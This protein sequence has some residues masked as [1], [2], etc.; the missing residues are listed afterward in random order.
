MST[1]RG[2]LLLAVVLPACHSFFVPLPSLSPP[3]PLWLRKRTGTCAASRNS[4]GSV[5]GDPRHSMV[6]KA[7]DMSVA[8]LKEELKARHGIQPETS[9][10]RADLVDKLQ[11]LR[12]PRSRQSG[13]HG[14]SGRKPRGIGGGVRGADPAAE[15]SWARF[16]CYYQKQLESLG[17]DALGEMF[18]ALLRP[19]PVTFRVS[20][21]REVGGGGKGTSLTDRRLEVRRK[22]EELLSSGQDE[23]DAPQVNRVLQQL[24]WYPNGAAWQLNLTPMAMR[25]A[26]F[27]KL[28]EWLVGESE[29]GRIWRQEAVSMVPVLLLE[30]KP[31]MTVL[32][33]C[34]APGSKTSQLLEGVTAPL[35]GE[36]VCRG[37][38]VANDADIARAQMMVHRCKALRSPN[39]VVTCYQGQSFPRLQVPTSHSHLPKVTPSARETSP[40]GATR[41]LAPTLLGGG[42]AMEGSDANSEDQQ[43]RCG[44]EWRNVS[45]DAVLCDV[46]CSGDGTLRKYVVH[47][48]LVAPKMRWHPDR[49]NRM[50]MVQLGILE[51]GLDL[52]KVGGLIAYS[53]CS[54]NPIENEAVVA[55]L[56]EEHGAAVEL[57][58]AHHDLR[59][60]GLDTLPGICTWLVPDKNDVGVLFDTFEEVPQSRK[61]KEQRKAE[62]YAG[63]V[64]SDGDVEERRGLYKT[65]FAPEEGKGMC[66][67]QCVRILPHTQDTGGFF[68][69][70]LRKKSPIKAL[71]FSVHAASKQRGG[72]GEESSVEARD[73]SCKDDGD[74]D[75]EDEDDEDEDEDE[76]ED[77]TTYYSVREVAGGREVLDSMRDFYQL[78]QDFPESHLVARSKR[79]SQIRYVSPEVASLVQA[80]GSDGSSLTISTAGI[81]AFQNKRWEQDRV[82]HRLCMEGLCAI[83]PWMGSRRKLR[84]GLDLYNQL[85]T[86]RDLPLDQVP[87]AESLEVGTFACSLETGQSNGGGRDPWA[88]V[89]WRGG[90]KVL[91]FADKQESESLQRALAERGDD[92]GK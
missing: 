17:E 36:R 4:D 19:L 75:D 3:S 14:K 77:R 92:G 26:P 80:R 69:A 33:M 20:E 18:E 15:K 76:D 55:A 25:E 84:L 34:S 64:E 29:A 78:S 66:L 32:D 28:Q 67:S 40:S 50:H 52:V 11:K 85:L 13:A 83:E 81:L 74:S 23:S 73:G 45:F 35:P 56:L 68:I 16:C 42:D 54:L 71:R 8:E 79:M 43:G 82:R 57:V 65:M 47:E 58:D 61:A 62:G 46:P 91:L 6:K 12:D 38:V 88:L 21:V 39:L 60:R 63:L 5:G 31:G 86:Q 53:T 9:D 90:H 51:K 48:G 37:A 7:R 87:G 89:C 49:G 59:S 72:G 24:E 10:K 27:R 70:L 44:D 1:G 41:P 30:P 2:L 22:V